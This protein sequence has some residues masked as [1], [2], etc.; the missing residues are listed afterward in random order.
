MHSSQLFLKKHFVKNVIWSLSKK[1]HVAK[2][3]IVFDDI[4]YYITGYKDTAEIECFKFDS[5]HE[6]QQSSL[7]YFSGYFYNFRG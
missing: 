7:Q 4:K 3:L 5:S 2:N 1:G 6:N